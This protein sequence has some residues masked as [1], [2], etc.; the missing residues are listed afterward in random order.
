M[1][2]ISYN[3]TNMSKVPY[4]LIM[5]FYT[6]KETKCFMSP[7]KIILYS[8]VSVLNVYCILVCFLCNSC[9]LIMCDAGHAFMNRSV[10]WKYMKYI[11]IQITKFKIGHDEFVN[12]W[13]EW[14][15]SVRPGLK[16]W[17]DKKG[18][19]CR[20]KNIWKTYPYW[21]QILCGGNYKRNG[22]KCCTNESHAYNRLAP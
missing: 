7:T 22:F 5:L 9:V 13:L 6:I 4:K 1:K 17:R 18:E 3:K 11:W 20:T 19:G 15:R 12:K 2:I 10:F 21:R 16:F 8:C 14:G